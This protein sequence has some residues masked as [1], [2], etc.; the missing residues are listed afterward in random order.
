MIERALVSGIQAGHRFANFPVGIS[1]LLSKLLC[2]GSE[3]SLHH[4]IPALRVRPCTRQMEQQRGL[5]RLT[6]ALHPL[7]Q[8]DSRV[9]R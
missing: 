9:N 8:W 7:P 3:T 6:S 5:P 2:P 4:A 1:L